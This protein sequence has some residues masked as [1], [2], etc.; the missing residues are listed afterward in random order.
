MFTLFLATFE[1]KMIRSFIQ[2]VSYSNI[3]TCI[4]IYR[5]KI[6]RILEFKSAYK[7]QNL[8]LI[9][10][11]SFDALF[12]HSEYRLH[13]YYICKMYILIKIGYRSIIH[14]QQVVGSNKTQ[15]KDYNRVSLYN[16]KGHFGYDPFKKITG[17]ITKKIIVL[18]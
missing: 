12:I 15:N 4:V 2:N 8:L 18:N 9:I 14:I 7:L 5:K 1:R 11:L 16:L 10:S 3:H 6:A 17:L 13:T